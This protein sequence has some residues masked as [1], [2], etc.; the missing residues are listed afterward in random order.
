MEARRLKSF[1]IMFKYQVKRVLKEGNEYTFDLYE[2]EN[3]F[4]ESGYIGH[5]TLKVRN[6][7]ELI[8][9]ILKMEGSE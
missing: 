2:W 6:K 3:Q 5:F 9:K 7:Q 1:P 8:D 4:L